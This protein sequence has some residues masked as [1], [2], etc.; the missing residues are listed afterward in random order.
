[1]D[2]FKSL[3]RGP[4]TIIFALILSFSAEALTLP[5]IPVTNQFG[6]ESSLAKHLRGNGILVLGFYGCKHICNFMVKN[7]SRTL[8]QR[9]NYPQVVFLSVDETEGPRDALSLRKR[10]IGPEKDRWSFLVSDKESI[11]RLATALNFQFRRDPA[12]GVITHEI[13]LYTLKDGELL[14]S[15]SKMQLDEKDL[16]F[17]SGPQKT[18]QEL[19]KFCSEFDPSKSK[20]GTLVMNFLMGMC[21]LFLVGA[22]AI[23]YHL[24]KS[25]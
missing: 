19:K 12:T 22:S 16:D 24:R 9:P 8:S 17:A 21:L 23:F 5:D 4:L 10:I 18:L 2:M 11:Q 15:M 13:G 1:M 25:R 14:K 20:Y 7:L 6:V 3:L